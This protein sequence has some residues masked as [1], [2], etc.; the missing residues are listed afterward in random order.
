MPVQP[1][2]IA[3]GEALIDIT[4]GEGVDLAYPGGSPANVALALGRLGR[5]PTLVT[6]FAADAH[7]ELLHG[8][9]QQAGV[10]VVSSV[11]ATGRTSTARVTWD[12]EKNASYE[13]DIAWDVTLDDLP[14]ADA[15]HVG[16]IATVLE[17]GAD[18][19]LAFVTA[20]AASALVS[21][22]PNAR[23]QITPDRDAALARVERLFALSDVVK[24]SDEDLEWYYPGV[25]AEDAAAR[26]LGLGAKLVALTRG[27]SGALIFRG[28]D[29]IKAPAPKVTVVDTIAAGDT[30]T[31]GLVDALLTLGAHGPSARD[32]LSRLTVDEL[33]RAASWAAT[34]AAITVSRPGADP[35]TR[36]ELEAALRA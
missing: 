10:N 26:I 19:V 5:T 35:P 9:L 34:A 30:F 2:V 13:F 7:G 6:Q 18:A 3:I 27:G 21:F 17:P 36:A 15:I 23:P 22:D 31:A 33:H 20:R 16:S 32:V 28:S 14:A 12:A 4:P 24:V 1:R 25:A 11:P 29:V 8:W